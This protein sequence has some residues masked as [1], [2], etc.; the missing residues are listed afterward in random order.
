[1]TTQAGQAHSMSPV[2]WQAASDARTGDHAHLSQCLQ[3]ARSRTLALFAAF[4][5]V[6]KPAG[7]AV[8]YSPQLNPPLWELGHIAWFQE[9]W[10][11]RN[12]ERDKGEHADPDCGRPPSLLA[13]ADALYDSGR[14]PHASRWHLPL[15]G[16][17]A[18]RDFLAQTL[19]QT[20]QLLAQSEASD[21]ALYF[22]R[23]ALFHE[24]MHA[25]AAVYMASALDIPLPRH[26]AMPTGPVAGAGPEP[27][28][29]LHVSA[30]EW[31]LGWGGAPG[32]AF[33]NEWVQ[34]V[35]TLSAFEIDAE[36]V[37]W[38]RYLPFVESG[39][40]QDARWWSPEGWAWLLTTDSPGPA[41]DLRAPRY[42][43]C[44]GGTWLTR[45]AGQWQALDLP[46]PAVHL[47]A[48]E[49]DAWCRW[50]GRRLPTEAEWECAA[51]TAPGFVWGDVWD[52]TASVFQPFGGFA[53]HPYRDYSRPWF[54]THRALKGAC[55]ATSPRMRHPKYRNFFT[56]GRND[57]FAGFRSCAVEV[58]SR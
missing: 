21:D 40:Y 9:W 36:P 10:L 48:H 33:D 49:A 50:A 22:F 23:L 35:A 46:A 58:A 38:A 28:N 31:T 5:E 7:L 20:L 3:D 47:S 39:G 17:A 25:E 54:G 14:V 51:L 26:A 30:R 16:A 34:Q 57:I 19:Q 27:V 18:T 15:P 4:E 52:W 24:D 42:L 12:P 37:R 6:L 45:G 2:H 41:V 11:G 29:A 55:G 13:G 56:P 44:D 43:R 32:F 1:M 8:P 53:P